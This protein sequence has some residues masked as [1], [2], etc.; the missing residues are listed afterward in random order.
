MSTLA[1]RL[2]AIE[3]RKTKAS[4]VTWDDYY[5]AERRQASRSLPRLHA[6][7]EEALRATIEDRPVNQVVFVIDDDERRDEAIIAAWEVA[8]GI[9]PHEEHRGARDRLAAALQ[10]QANVMADRAES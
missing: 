2:A 10:R 5:A 1:R 4:T 8:R 7:F 6:R 9:D 3:R